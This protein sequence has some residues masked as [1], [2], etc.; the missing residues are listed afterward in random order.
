M[1]TRLAALVAAALLAVSL[2]A[3]DSRAKVQGTITDT[4]QAVIA[5]ANVQLLNEN[6]GVQ[7]NTQTNASGQYMFDFVIPGNYSVT[8]ELQGFKKYLQKNILVQSRGDITVNTA[9][10]LGAT[11][12]AI[13][14]EGAPIAVQFNTSTMGLTLDTKMANQL[15]IIHRN[16]FLLATLNP[17]TVLRSSTEQSP[18]HHWAAS[19]IDVGGN[20]STKNDIIMDG[21]PSMTP[22]SLPTL[23]PWMRFPK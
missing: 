1:R 6:T 23:L 11:R 22:R 17:A 7:V 5:G 4:S 16:P 3:Q 19:Q 18:F 12:D 14:V 15:P 20:T 10:E 8:V 13:T 21:S 2:Q 9:L